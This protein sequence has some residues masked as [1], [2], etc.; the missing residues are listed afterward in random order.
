MKDTSHEWTLGMLS[1]NHLDQDQ[2]SVCRFLRRIISP[3]FS[4]NQ[5]P[6]VEPRHKFHFNDEPLNKA[7]LK[8]DNNCSSYR[9]LEQS[10]QKDDP[11]FQ[12]PRLAALYAKFWNTKVF[13]IS[14]AKDFN[15]VLEI[16]MAGYLDTAAHKFGHQGINLNRL[17]PWQEPCCSAMP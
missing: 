5:L 12:I 15:Q 13:S 11:Q 6:I 14:V 10:I 8:G 2:A 7:I 9:E 17:C 16:L 4:Q 3:P 1:Y